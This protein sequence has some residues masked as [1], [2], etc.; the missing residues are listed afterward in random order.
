[1]VLFERR[2]NACDQRKYCRSLL[3]GFIRVPIFGDRRR[4]A[5]RPHPV[6]SAR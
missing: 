5:Q 3:L 1:V 4:W 2:K 6:E